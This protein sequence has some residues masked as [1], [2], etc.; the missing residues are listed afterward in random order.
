MEVQDKA[1]QE[2]EHEP[3]RYQNGWREIGLFLQAQATCNG[4]TEK[5]LRSLH[6]AV[7]RWEALIKPCEKIG[8]ILAPSDVSCD[9][10]L[11]PGTLVNLESGL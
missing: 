11:Q 2:Q 6:M 7:G 5:E 4:D 1:D 10:P 9:V 3:V 8:P